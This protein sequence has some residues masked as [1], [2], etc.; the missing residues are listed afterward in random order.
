MLSRAL[1]N[2][3]IVFK[4]LALNYSVSV[5][6]P[7]YQC[8]EQLYKLILTVLRICELSVCHFVGDG[9]KKHRDV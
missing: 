6:L 1:V 8:S 3:L 5:A 4:Y 7:L 2:L 9:M